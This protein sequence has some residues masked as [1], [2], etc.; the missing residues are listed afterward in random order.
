[1]EAIRIKIEKLASKSSHKNEKVGACSECY[2]EEECV[3]VV[4]VTQ[5]RGLPEVISKALKRI[6]LKELMGT[7]I[8]EK[9][10]ILQKNIDLEMEKADLKSQ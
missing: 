9:I 5:E 6:T 1:M 2:D 3:D 10:K 8:K 7:T 4:P